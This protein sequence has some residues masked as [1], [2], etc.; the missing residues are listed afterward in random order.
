MALVKQQSEVRNE[1]LLV[2]SWRV[3]SVEDYLFSSGRRWT[4][5]RRDSITAVCGRRLLGK[6]F[7][8]LLLFEC[9]GRGT[10]SN[11]GR[12][13]LDGARFVVAFAL[14]SRYNIGANNKLCTEGS[15]GAVRRGPR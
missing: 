6:A 10:D 11:F 12:T 7:G 4:M 14:G 13:K 1:T 5:G 3:D 2:S 8:L 9:L 15:A